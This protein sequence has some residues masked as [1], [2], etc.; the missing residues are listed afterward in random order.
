MYK[1]SRLVRFIV[2]VRVNVM[3]NFAKYKDCFPGIDAEALFA[4][5]VLHSLDHTMMDWNLKDALLLD[6]DH[7]RFWKMA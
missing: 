2:L 3:K 5:T 4:G 7:E 6:V 1:C